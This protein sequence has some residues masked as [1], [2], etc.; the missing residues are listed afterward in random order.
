[1][2]K[3]D[4]TL[5]E[6]IGLGDLLPA[7]RKMT[8]MT[9][10]EQLEIRV[11]QALAAQMTTEQMK[12]FEEFIDNSDEAGGL[13]WL[14]RNFPDYKNIVNELFADLKLEIIDNRI[15]VR[16]ILAE[17]APLPIIDFVR[18]LT[19]YE[20]RRLALDLF[21]HVGSMEAICAASVE[22]LESVP[23]LTDVLLN[24]IL[25]RVATL[26]LDLEKPQS[27]PGLPSVLVARLMQ[28]FGSWE[29]MFSA[30]DDEVKGVKGVGDKTLQRIRALDMTREVLE[31]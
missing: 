19:G 24:K 15:E 18:S 13:S 12:E 5:L 10:Y 28:K 29:N 6:E 26:K 31:G 22:A 21:V 2:I 1:M 11:G 7:E 9:I 4:D 14:E 27:L 16:G 17:N 3:L 20:D 30:S 8:L 25:R 23:G